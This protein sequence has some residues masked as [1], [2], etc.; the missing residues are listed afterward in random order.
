MTKECTK[1]QLKKNWHCI[2]I[3][4]DKGLLQKRSIG[5]AIFMATKTRLVENKLED[6]C[7]G[8]DRMG[9]TNATDKLN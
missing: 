5:Q 8:A 6:G 2:K 1:W 9:R 7:V 3:H 4:H